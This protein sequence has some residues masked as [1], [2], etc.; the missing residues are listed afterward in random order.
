MS[1]VWNSTS[2][3]QAGDW[4][5]IPT[6]DLWC[7]GELSNKDLMEKLFVKIV[8]EGTWKLMRRVI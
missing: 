8:R 6:E 7:D 1:E 3:A 2:D 5:E 4:E